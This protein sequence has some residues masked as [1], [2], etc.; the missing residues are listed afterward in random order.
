MSEFNCTINDK[1]TLKYDLEI[2]YEH[3]KNLGAEFVF[4]SVM[5]NNANK[6]NFLKKFN[7]SKS[8]YNVYLY[9][10]NK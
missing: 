9:K 8:P 6:L 1:I 2:N 5:I 7:D 10:L 4:S 3:L